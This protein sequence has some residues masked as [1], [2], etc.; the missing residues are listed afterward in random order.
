MFDKVMCLI[1]A[2]SGIGNITNISMSSHY[3][4]IDFYHR[5]KKYL[6]NLM[7]VE[8]GADDNAD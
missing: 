2:I 7:P 5:G 3:A 8:E 6:L 1:N 4:S